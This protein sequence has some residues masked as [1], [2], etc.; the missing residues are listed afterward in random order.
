MLRVLLALL[1]GCTPASAFWQTRDSTYDN[2]PG[3]GGPPPACTPVCMG[4][5]V[6]TSGATWLAW[7]SAGR[8][9]THSY[10]G[11]VADV[12]DVATENTNGTQLI[13]SG[14]V[15]VAQPTGS[16][17]CSWVVGG[18][19][20]DL[21]TTCSGGSGCEVVT[22]YDQSGGIGNIT[23]GPGGRQKLI[24]NALNTYPCVNVSPADNNLF[25]SP[26]FSQAQPFSMSLIAKVASPGA[27]GGVISFFGSDSG[28]VRD[29]FDNS[30]TTK[31]MIYAGVVP[32]GQTKGS[33]FSAFNDV[34]NSTSPPALSTFSSI[35]SVDGSPL[36]SQNVGTSAFASNKLSIGRI[37]DSTI[38][39]GLLCEAGLLSGA[40]N[41]TDITAMNANQ[42]AAYGSW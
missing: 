26:S 16:A 8:C 23:A 35:E 10:S 29:G 11:V 24:P 28:L 2:P 22:W 25:L 39:T 19:C 31:H 42:H 33:G 37:S 18:L 30:A 36:S 14:G 41:T 1:L 40:L 4:D 38:T 13:C 5:L 34:F 12:V 3:A 21:T 27:L 7:Y 20:T 6:L 32:S 9:F 15:V 17:H